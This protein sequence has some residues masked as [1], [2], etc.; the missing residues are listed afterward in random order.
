M[1]GRVIRD[2]EALVVKGAYVLV[3]KGQLYNAEAWYYLPPAAVD[4]RYRH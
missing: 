2:V 1:D 3:P 4:T